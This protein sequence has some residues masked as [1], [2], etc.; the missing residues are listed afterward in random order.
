MDT[1]HPSIHFAFFTA[2]ASV[3]FFHCLFFII[4]VTNLFEVLAALTFAS[5]SLT[6]TFFNTSA[7]ICHLRNVRIRRDGCRLPVISAWHGLL[8]SCTSAVSSWHW[9]KSTRCPSNSGPSTQANFTSPPTITR[10]APHIPVPSTMIGFM[11]TMVGM[12]FIKAH[13]T[14]FFVYSR[15]VLQNTTLK[16]K[17]IP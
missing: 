17:T 8:L 7:I 4:T 2:K 3:C 5:C 11:L 9:S 1:G 12:R 10:H 16:Y 15:K 13:L 6:G 14:V